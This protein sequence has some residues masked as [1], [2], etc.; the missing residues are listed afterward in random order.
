MENWDRLVSKQG[1]GKLRQFSGLVKP[2]ES[3]VR[4]TFGRAMC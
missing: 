3:G 1:F 2:D 4:D